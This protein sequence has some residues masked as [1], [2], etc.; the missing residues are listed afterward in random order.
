MFLTKVLQVH[1]VGIDI[2]TGKKY[3]EICGSTQNVECPNVSRKEYQL[4]DIS[5][6]GDT[7]PVSLLLDDGTMKEDLN[8]P[9]GEL[10]E[11]IRAAFDDG[12]DVMVTVLAAMNKEMI[13]SF[14]A[15]VPK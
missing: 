11:Q 9:G 3:E 8:L 1:L 4:V 12:Q 6:E 7:A 5:G 13:V 14:K 10:A 2:F 15:S